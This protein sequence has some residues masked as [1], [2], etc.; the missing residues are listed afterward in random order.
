MIIKRYKNKQTEAYPGMDSTEFDIEWI[1]KNEYRIIS[2]K[3]TIGMSDDTLDVKITN[4][5]EKFYDCYVR[6]G[7]YALYLNIEKLKN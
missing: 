3:P 2:K 5:S 4:N 7:E 6:Y 1:A